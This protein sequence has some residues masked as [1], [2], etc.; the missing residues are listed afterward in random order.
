MH[1][2]QTPDKST[3]A[4]AVPI[5]ATS[6]YGAQAGESARAR[7]ATLQPYRTLGGTPVKTRWQCVVL[8]ARQ[9]LAACRSRACTCRSLDL[10]PPRHTQ[11]HPPAVFDSSKHA[12]DLFALKAFGNIYT[13][14]MNPTTDVFEKRMTAL[15]GGVAAVAT[16]SG[17]AALL[18]AL[19]TIC[20]A[21]DSIVSTT[22]LYGGTY[23]AFA[24]TFP[25]LG[26]KVRFV[27][28]DSPSEWEAAVDDTTKA[29][30]T[31]SV[32]NPK[33]NVPDFAGIAAVAKKHGIALVVDNT[34]GAAGWL[35]RPFEHGA[36]VVM[37][38][39][40]KFIGGHGTAIGGVVIDGGNFDWSVTHAD[41][42]PKHPMFTEP[43]PGY[44][45]LRFWDVF[46]TPGPFGANI[47]FAIRAR[48][49]GLRD[50][51]AC[52]SPFNSF[53]FLQ[54]R[55]GDWGGGDT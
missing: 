11:T 10:V 47:A 43:S 41:G 27:A 42:T 7:C 21:G 6:S 35:V 12:A 2:G 1:A 37:H 3:N 30:F 54:V 18:L 4:V 32:G 49:E 9:C 14:I 24:N 38:S 19:T 20:K 55:W 45:G 16:A 50:T 44:H 23:S 46:G 26:I 25:R 15:E 53:L 28:G 36:N 40:T 52:M 8:V 48:V 51:G 17:Q 5:Y 29:F 34:F 13:R 39:A 31:E 33:A 22:N